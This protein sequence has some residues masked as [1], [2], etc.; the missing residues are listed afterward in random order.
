MNMEKINVNSMDYR[1]LSKEDKLKVVRFKIN[2][3]LSDTS[4]SKAYEY[5]NGKKVGVPKDKLGIFKDLCEREKSLSKYVTISEEPV[6]ERPTIKA[7]VVEDEKKTSSK[8]INEMDLE[9]INNRIKYIKKY[10]YEMTNLYKKD[11]YKNAKII[12]IQG[13]DSNSAYIPYSK[14]G[15]YKTLYKYLKLLEMKKRELE[16]IEVKLTEISNDKKEDSYEYLTEDDNPYETGYMQFTT[17]Y[18]AKK[19]TP[20]VESTSVK[21]NDTTSVKS[22]NECKE[23][24]VIDNKDNKKEKKGFG[25]KILGFLAGTA[26]IGG[27]CKGAKWVGNKF[28]NGFNKVKSETKEVSEILRKNKVK[29]AICAWIVA[30]TAVVCSFLPKSQ[31]KK[32]KPDDIVKPTSVVETTE[33]STKKDDIIIDEPVIEE[34]TEVVTENKEYNLGE[35]V[36]IKDNSYIYTNSY[37]ATDSTNKCTPYYNGSYDREVMGVTYELDGNLYTI[38]RDDMNASEKVNELISKG[39]KQTA[40]L[41]VRSDLVNTGDYEGY[42]NIDSIKRVR[43]R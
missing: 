14:L 2:K 9:E 10:L 7:E 17:G 21:S 13:Y 20:V 32:H 23:L 18:T 24:M 22:N 37:D 29:T 38:Y 39:A 15:D 43:T 33:P 30:A 36:N 5:Y 28:K 41:V 42:Y 6:M 16:S 11:E 12:K 34:P 19:D 25:K 40:V 26:I 8:N 27:I 35:S 3:L 4:S 1:K 31:S